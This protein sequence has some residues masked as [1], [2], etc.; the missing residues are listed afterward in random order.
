MKFRQTQHD[1]PTFVF[2]RDFMVKKDRFMPMT[3]N[4]PPESSV[5]GVV[6]L[7]ARDTV[8]N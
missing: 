8:A 1:R 4:D 3:G 6:T 5:C 2:L 7:V